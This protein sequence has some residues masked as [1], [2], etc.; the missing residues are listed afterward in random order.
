MHPDD[1]TG[2]TDR[3]VQSIEGMFFE[4]FFNPAGIANQNDWDL[5]LPGGSD[6]AF[7]LDAGSIVATHG[8]DRDNDATFQP[9]ASYSSVPTISLPL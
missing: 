3:Y 5:P 6:S 8:I 9:K 4:L 1:F 7:N 2:V